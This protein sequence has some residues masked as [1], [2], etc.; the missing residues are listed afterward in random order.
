M[1]RRTT[2]SCLAALLCLS[3]TTAFAADRDAYSLS[4]GANYSSGDYGT[5]TNTRI[6]SIPVTGQYDTGPWSL[7]LTV[8]YLY[9]S[10]GTAIPGIG[11]VPNSNPNARGRG[12]ASSSASGLGDIV[13]AGVYNAYYDRAAGAGVDVTG[14]IK[15]GTADANKG[16]GTGEDD[17]SAQVD[18]YQTY[19]KATLFAGIGYTVFGSS[20]FLS[21]DDAVNIALGVNYRLDDSRSVGV[22][23]DARAPVYADISEQRELMGYW[24]RR[25]DKTWKAQVYVLKG[26]ADGSP[27]WG[28]GAVAV[29]AF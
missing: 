13:V 10:G 23:L 4:V 26:F 8:P 1:Y 19:G 16:M 5:G 11:Q 2:T 18:G 12:G 14:K 22:R 3:A 27:D 28:V 9:V 17:V 20:S 6:F 24:V 29:Y 15:F 7:R 25:I 21:L